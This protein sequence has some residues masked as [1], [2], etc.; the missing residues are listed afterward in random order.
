MSQHVILDL[1]EHPVDK[2]YYYKI[3]LHF[4]NVYRRLARGAPRNW[5]GGFQILIETTLIL[6]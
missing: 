2:V 6:G 3:Q 4:W 1:T 5:L